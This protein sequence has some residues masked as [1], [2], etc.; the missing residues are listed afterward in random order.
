MASLNLPLVSLMHPTLIAGPFHREGW[1]YEEQYDGCRMVAYKDGTA[2]RLIN[3]AGQDH[4]QRFPELV[5]ALGALPARTLILDG[6]VCIFD[7]Q[8]I[9]RFEWLWRR[10]TGETATPALFMAFDCLYARRKDLRARAL[11]VRRQ[12]LEAEVEGRHHVLPARRLADEGLTA[13]AE[14]LARGYEGLV[15]KDPESRYV[16]GRTLA[17]LKVQQPHYREGERGWE[18]TRR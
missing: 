6:E 14:V 8:L 11:R 15:A 9:S 16:P 1:V 7:P 10:P 13:W 2:V 18:S 4:A 17:W 5:A 12:V 3:Q